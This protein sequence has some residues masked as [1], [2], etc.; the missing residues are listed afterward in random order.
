MSP[1]IVLFAYGL[2]TYSHEMF[3]SESFRVLNRSMFNYER[4]PLDSLD[5]ALFKPE[6]ILSIHF[7][8]RSGD[9]CLLSHDLTC[10]QV[11]YF[12]H[13]LLELCEPY[14]PAG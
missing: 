3:E 11:E 1:E 7:E 6:L 14:I 12:D 2:S 9:L 13:R 8:M 5:T 4:F 10:T